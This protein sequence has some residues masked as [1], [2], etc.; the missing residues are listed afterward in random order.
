VSEGKITRR[1]ATILA[2]LAAAGGAMVIEGKEATDDEK[3]LAKQ[4][5]AIYVASSG[6]GFEPTPQMIAERAKIAIQAWR[7]LEKKS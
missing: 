5:I 1:D 7:L 4:T 6:M 3:D 2:V